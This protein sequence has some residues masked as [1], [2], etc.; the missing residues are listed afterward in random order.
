MTRK[1]NNSPFSKSNQ[2]SE[3]PENVKETGIK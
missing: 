1:Q 2:I 3:F